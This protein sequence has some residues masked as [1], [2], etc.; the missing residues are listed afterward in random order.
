MS[1][2]VERRLREAS[3]DA[4][5][6]AS[7]VDD[8]AM[9]DRIAQRKRGHAWL[10]PAAA[11]AAG[12]GVAATVAAI[13]LSA[14]PDQI[15]VGG[16]PTTSPTATAD[17]GPTPRPSP[18]PA[19]GATGS[20]RCSAADLPATIAPQPELPEAVAAL[21]ERLAALA[22]ACDVEEL[23]RLVDPEQFTFSFGATD[24]P[25]D[26]WRRAESDAAASTPGPMESLRRILEAPPG[27]METESAGSAELWVWPRLHLLDPAQTPAEQLD[28]AVSEVVSTGL[29]NREELEAVIEGGSGYLG[30]RVIVQVAEPGEAEWIVFV[31]GD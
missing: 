2:N 30:Y 22:V 10:I 11:A 21:R 3:E 12:L 6:V 25:A 19:A 4:R 14:P 9:L 8:V 13:A 31:A 5:R 15:I 18:S 23:A 7:S 16:E 27:R 24:D 17:P 1:T 29:Y 20:A 26:F 28:D